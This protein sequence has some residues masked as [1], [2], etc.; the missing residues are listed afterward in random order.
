MQSLFPTI[1]KSLQEVPHGSDRQAARLR[2]S[3]GTLA[4]LV[5]FPQEL[6]QVEWYRFGHFGFRGAGTRS[7][8]YRIAQIPSRQL[9]RLRTGIIRPGLPTVPEAGLHRLSR[10]LE[11]DA[12]LLRHP[13]DRDR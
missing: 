5:M 12:V 10:R 2:E 1:A 7:L 11:L 3:R 9:T 6:A 13:P 4:K 8:T